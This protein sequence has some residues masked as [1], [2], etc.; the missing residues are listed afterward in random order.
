MQ[1]RG[2]TTIFIISAVLIVGI[3]FFFFFFLRMESEPLFVSGAEQKS[4]QN[5]LEVCLRDHLYE[6]VQLISNQGGYIQNPLHISYKLGGEEIPFDISY[7]CY[8]HMD[9]INCINQQPVLLSHLEG[10]I[11]EYLY[12]YS[13]NCFDNLIDAMRNEGYQI[14]QND[15]EY[16]DLEI[17]INRNH[18]EVLI[19]GRLIASKAGETFEYKNF[20]TRFLS[21]LYGIVEI[22][23]RIVNDESFYCN[24][25]YVSHNTLYSDYLINR[26]S[27]LDGSRIYLVENKDS[28]ENFRFA[29]RG[30]VTSGGII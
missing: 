12:D 26:Y 19:E 24:F 25:D 23:K 1:K 8:S 30:C 17:N 28:E 5:F 6:G 14:S 20:K 15:Y 16:K 7:L 21:N 27:A 13:E 18:I 22:V 3:I 11:K 4:T 9:N 10:E 29:I 2:Q